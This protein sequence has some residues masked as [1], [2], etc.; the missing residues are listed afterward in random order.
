MSVLVKD[1]WVGPREQALNVP[2][3]CR[4]YGPGKPSSMLSIDVWLCP[5]LHWLAQRETVYGPADR[6][7]GVLWIMSGAL[8]L[9]SSDSIQLCRWF[10]KGC[11]IWGLPT[12]SVRRAYV[13]WR[14]KCMC[15]IDRVFPYRVYI[16]SNRRDSRIWVT[17]CSWQSS[18]S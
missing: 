11:H 14:E 12:G 5:V 4:W 3:A 7:A 6:S 17:T 16:N 10:V 13:D 9:R 15:Y 2:I 1:Q 8:F 18:R